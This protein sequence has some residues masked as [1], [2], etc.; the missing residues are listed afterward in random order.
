MIRLVLA[1][2]GE[3]VWHEENRYAGRTDVALTV[4]GMAQ[5]VQLAEWARGAKLNAVWSSPLS[6]ARLTALPAAEAAFLPLQVN[7]QLREIDFGRAEGKTDAEMRMLF[8]EE[9]AAFVRDPVMHYLPDGEDPVRAAERGTAA[10]YAIAEA[11]GEGG[12]AL[13]V[14][15]NTLLRLVL[16]SLLGIPLARYRSSFPS[17]GNG[18]ITEIAMSGSSVGLLSFNVPLTEYEERYG[19]H[20]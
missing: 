5:A 3:T 2:H 14:A 11:S 7:E 10:L 6:R 13:I 8:P 4:R 15:H 19:E 16:C 17:F 1:R 18:T 20:A 12:R 9:R